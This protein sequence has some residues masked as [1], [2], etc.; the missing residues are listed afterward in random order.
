MTYPTTF[1]ICFLLG[2][3]SGVQM[4]YLA[5]AAGAVLIFGVDPVTPPAVVSSLA[6]ALIVALEI[7]AP[8]DGGLL[9]EAVML[10][11]FIA[12]VAA[13]TAMISAIVFLA[14]REAGQAEAAAEFEYERSEALLTNVLPAVVADRLKSR[15]RQ[16]IAD[17]YDEASILFAD[18]AGFTAG[19]SQTS[20]V[21][22]VK[23]LNDVF[24]AFDRLVERHGLEKIKTT[25]DNYMVVSGVPLPRA[26]HAAAL[27]RLGIDMLDATRGMRDPNGLNVAIRIGIASGPVVAGVVGT[28]KFFYDVWG[29]AVNVAS[30]MEST[31]VPGRIQVSPE[32][33]DATKGEFAFESRGPVEVKGKGQMTTWLL[34]G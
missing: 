19:A 29:D 10:G 30:R 27:V 4:H 14:V 20:P 28:T 22:L 33:H 3:D 34:T 6:L 1:V 26:D 32:T 9:S 7:F 17:R 13:A 12:T 31:G 8:H 18:M 2:T 23:F 16:V 25:G 24:S 5:Y 11:G 21:D 15:T